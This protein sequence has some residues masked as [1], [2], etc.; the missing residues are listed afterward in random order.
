M[1]IKEHTK[2]T[3]IEY[4]NR[5]TSEN[6]R[7]PNTH[8]TKLRLIKLGLLQNNC[9]ICSIVNWNGKFLSLHIDHIDGNP[10]NNAITNLRLLCPNCHSQTDTYCGKNVNK[11]KKR[12]YCLECNKVL[13]SSWTSRCANC[14]LKVKY[15]QTKITWPEKEQL[16]KLIMS[17][18][19]EHIAKELGVSSNAIKKHCYKVG[20]DYQAVKYNI[21]K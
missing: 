4:L 2:E 8:E 14:F 1:T 5:L 13:S 18:K 3:L 6:R 12:N 9:S 11:N 10:R 20:I 17:K 7:M 15:H 21:Q 16:I 19:M